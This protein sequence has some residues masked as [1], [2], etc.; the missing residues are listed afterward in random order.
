M[1]L[2]R[3]QSWRRR[4]DGP[5][6]SC[7]GLALVPPLFAHFLLCI[8][9]PAAA[10][11]RGGEGVKPVA[12]SNTRIQMANTAAT[13]QGPFD[14]LTRRETN[15]GAAS[16]RW[17]LFFACMKRL[18]DAARPKPSRRTTL[19]TSRRP[20][21]FAQLSAA[22]IRPSRR[23]AKRSSSSASWCWTWTWAWFW[24]WFWYC[25]CWPLSSPMWS[26]DPVL[27]GAHEEA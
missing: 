17:L 25:S 3:Y 20:A 12:H 27:P 6:L 23:T 4:R 8:A 19:L 2:G 18:C 26:S 21:P 16:P 5:G 22:C 13:A 1:T 11:R 15:H 9:R 10:G 7:M 14:D 24:F